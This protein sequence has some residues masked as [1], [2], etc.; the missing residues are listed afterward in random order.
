MAEGQDGCQKASAAERTGPHDDRQLMTAD[1]R[2]GAGG[3]GTAG[4]QRRFNSDL[5][6]ER[7]KQE[8]KARKKLK[9]A[10]ARMASET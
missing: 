6:L 3:L 5:G 1:A 4:S 7:R 8:A 9:R 2:R 10:A